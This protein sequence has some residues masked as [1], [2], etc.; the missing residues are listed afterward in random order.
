MDGTT[1][2][3]LRSA[4]GV[5]QAGFAAGSFP[6]FYTDQITGAPCGLS[7]QQS[8]PI[9]LGRPLCV[10]SRRPYPPRKSEALPIRSHLDV[11]SSAGRRSARSAQAFDRRRHAAANAKPWVSGWDPSI[12]PPQVEPLSAVS[13]RANDYAHLQKLGLHRGED[14]NWRAQRAWGQCMFRRCGCRKY[15]PLTDRPRP[16]NSV[17]EKWLYRR[18]S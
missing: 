14:H 9:V 12:P 1:A 18:R 16:V 8:C 7:E 3:A 11:M 15:M 5:P 17:I 13:I 4:R 6:H 10:R 2:A